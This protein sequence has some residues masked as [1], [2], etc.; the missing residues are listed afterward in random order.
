[1]LILLM[2]YIL[3]IVISTTAIFT[4]SNVNDNS[5]TVRTS[6]DNANLTDAKFAITNYANLKLQLLNKSMKCSKEKINIKSK[7]LTAKG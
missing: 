2:L 1:M 4:N 6:T 5:V 3:L 7:Y